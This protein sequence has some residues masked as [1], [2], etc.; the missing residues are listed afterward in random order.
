MQEYKCFGGIFCIHIETEPVQTTYRVGGQ[1]KEIME[2][3]KQYDSPPSISGET[4]T[5]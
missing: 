3:K 2:H 5:H 1:E 4:V